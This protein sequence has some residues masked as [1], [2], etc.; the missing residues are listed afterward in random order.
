LD[1]ILP[2][3]SILTSIGHASHGHHLGAVISNMFE[4]KHPIIIVALIMTMKFL[5]GKVEAVSV[6]KVN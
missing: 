4:A 6:A 2:A 1:F 5:G 3:Q